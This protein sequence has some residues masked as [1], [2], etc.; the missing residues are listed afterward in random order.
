MPCDAPC[1]EGKARRTAQRGDLRSLCGDGRVER[2]D[3]PL[4]GGARGGRRAL[5]LCSS[6]ELALPWA[7][8][9]T[10]MGSL[11]A[12][13]AATALRFAQRPRRH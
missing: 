12:V 11:A 4:L 5:E 1:A 7:T 2:G 10:R 9:P 6:P 13:R 3:R 8:S